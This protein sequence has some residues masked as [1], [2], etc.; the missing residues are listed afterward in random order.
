M[1]YFTI[2]FCHSNFFSHVTISKINGTSNL[3][4]HY[5]EN[6]NDYAIIMNKS[7]DTNTESHLAYQ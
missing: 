5:R 1:D 7:I 6:M 3:Y 2:P 4:Q